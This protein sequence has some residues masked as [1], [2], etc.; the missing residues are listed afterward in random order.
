MSI[1]AGHL[2]D[3]LGKD[4]VSDEVLASTVGVDDCGDEVLWNVTVISE[5]LFCVLG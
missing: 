2:L 5:Q 1:S 4:F 3:N